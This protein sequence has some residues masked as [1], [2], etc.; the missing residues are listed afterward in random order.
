MS[1][2]NKFNHNFK[3]WYLGLL[4]LLNSIYLTVCSQYVLN[5]SAFGS[6]AN[7]SLF[8]FTKSIHFWTSSILIDWKDSIFK[9]CKN[10]LRM[11]TNSVK[12]WLFWWEFQHTSAILRHFLKHSNTFCSDLAASQYNKW[13]HFKIA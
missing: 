3:D 1:K 4:F 13:V 7:P 5:S 2:L 8:D 11:A 12:W 10:L 6:F 9:N